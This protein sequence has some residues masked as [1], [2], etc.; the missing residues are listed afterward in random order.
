MAIGAPVN[1]LVVAELL[2]GD[3][4]EDYYCPA[5]D[6]EW[7]DGSRSVRESDCPPMETG[8]AFVRRFTAEHVYHGRGTYNVRVTLRH[9]SRSL[10]AASAT[11][12]VN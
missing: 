11:V 3:Q 1:V 9:V 12:T 10:A 8:V 5:L 7:G 2:G 6:W 4:I